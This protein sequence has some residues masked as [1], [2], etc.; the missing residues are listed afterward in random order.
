MNVWVVK[1]IG[2]ENA[3]EAKIGPKQ[4]IGQFRQQ[5]AEEFNVPASN[6]ELST[7][8]KRLTNDSALM[9]KAVEEGE[10]VNVL[11]RSKAGI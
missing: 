3:T 7:D 2:E 9:C 6:V 1:G 4:T 5:C 11:P 8:T 10:T